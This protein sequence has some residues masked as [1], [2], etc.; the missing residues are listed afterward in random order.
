M[1]KFK[2]CIRSVVFV[3]IFTFASL[4]LPGL[5]SSGSAQTAVTGGLSG[6]VADSTGAIVPNATVTIV[7]TTT[8]DT[9]VLTTNA[10]GRYVAS[11]LKPGKFSISATAPSMQSNTTSVQNPGRSAIGRQPY[12]HS[13]RQ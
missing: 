7:N 2:R 10:E 3:A 1:N 12:G 6:V 9:R 4:T 11:F 8:G 5:M 13:S